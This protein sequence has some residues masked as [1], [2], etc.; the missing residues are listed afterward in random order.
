MG[1]QVP[2]QVMNSQEVVI[3]RSLLR[4]GVVHAATEAAEAILGPVPTWPARSGRWCSWSGT[5]A[6]PLRGGSV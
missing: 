4:T 3:L 2:G 5:R 1:Q 6:S